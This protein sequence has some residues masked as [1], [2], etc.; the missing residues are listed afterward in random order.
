MPT[1]TA[2]PMVGEATKM[3]YCPILHDLA[4]KGYCKDPDCGNCGWLRQAH[5]KGQWL[6]STCAVG[7]DMRAFFA[8]GLCGNC[9]QYSPVLALLKE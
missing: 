6:C 7:E 2:A 4:G 3:A 5:G 1:P 8:D 9:G